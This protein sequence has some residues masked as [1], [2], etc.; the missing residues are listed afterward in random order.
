ML[1]GTL[2]RSIS[3]E[4][5]ARWLAP[6]PAR[7]PRVPGRPCGRPAR[8]AVVRVPVA[9]PGSA[10]RARAGGRAGARRDVALRAARARQRCRRDHVDVRK[11][12]LRQRSDRRQQRATATEPSAY[13]RRR[14]EARG[15]NP[16]AAQYAPR[17]SG[18]A[19][20]TPPCIRHPNSPIMLDYSPL[21][22]GSFAKSA[23]EVLARQK[24]GITSIPVIALRFRLHRA[25][26]ASSL[27]F[28]RRLRPPSR[29]SGYAA[30]AIFRAR[31]TR[32]PRRGGAVPGLSGALAWP[33]CNLQTKS[34]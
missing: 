14:D 32:L 29:P 10:R 25:P 2:S 27:C 33:V 26:A 34:G 16:N 15:L 1:D 22:R 6:A 8:G 30:A 18:A 21:S 12:R 20:D 24:S 11:R 13:L 17:V 4:C 9:R 5:G 7:G 28:A 3:P 23:R 31:N 19:T